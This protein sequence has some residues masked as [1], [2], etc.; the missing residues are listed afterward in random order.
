MEVTGI[1]FAVYDVIFYIG[2]TLNQFG[3]GTGVI[4]FNGGADRAFKLKP[5]AFDGTFTEMVDATTQGN[6]I[7]FKGVTG[8]SFT[9]QTWGNGFNHVG[10]F[11]FQIREAAV[12]D[13]T[14]P[15]LNGSSIVD[16]KG[17][18][19]VTVGTLVTYT[20]TFSE[21]M[22][23][24]TVSAADFGNAGTSAVTIG[25]VTETSPGVFTVPV[26]PTSA[27]TLRL[28]V[29]AGAVLNDA[30]GNAL[31]TTADITDDTTLTVTPLNTAPTI[32]TY[33][34]AD[35]ATG[36]A[37]FA[38]LVATFSENVTIGTGNIT[39][40]NLSDGTQTTIVVTDTTQ[41][42][43]SGAVL[44]INPT[45]DLLSGK[46]YA[47][48]IAAT[49]IRDL[50]NNAFAGI[51]NDTAWNF[52]TLTDFAVWAAKFAGANLT[53]PNADF[54]GDRQSNDYERI[55]GLNPTNAASQN[56]FTSTSNLA[57]GNFSYTRRIPSLTGYSYTVWTSTNLTTWAQDTGAVQAPGAP[58]AEVETVTVNLSP[59]LLG[60]P[61]LFVRMRAAQP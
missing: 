33:S 48:Q 36:V 58:V 4:K 27:G 22:D 23:A 30:A 12:A 13:T 18:S 3:D 17:G 35:N 32:T 50:A 40:K 16:D 20:V 38:N 9:T 10:P 37:V 44:T 6:Y 19:P 28:R 24:S 52:T 39:L 59:A 7:V 34:P 25:T 55:W 53:D 21:D 2:A 60:G 45:A 56:P 1:P 41:V 51:A 42:S 29:N 54:D 49:A 15:T 46:N 47:V 11:G 26:T 31:V 8:S 61:R 43:I 14:P 5:G 57:V